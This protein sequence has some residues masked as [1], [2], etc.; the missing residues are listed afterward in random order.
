MIK[1]LK[2]TNKWYILLVS[3]ALLVGCANPSGSSDYSPELDTNIINEKTH[4]VIYNLCNEDLLVWVGDV[5]YIESW[6]KSDW[7]NAKF[8]SIC[9]PFILKSNKKFEVK[10]LP[11][12]GRIYCVSCQSMEYIKICS[13]VPVDYN[14]RF[15]FNT[16][17]TK[18]VI[19][20]T[21][22]KM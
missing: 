16:N 13:S 20:K 10:K 4:L 21:K 19:N 15:Y 2:M 8:E 1:N 3:L 12:T 17:K 5:E 7:N 18:I 22:L 6:G 11:P 14:A 9:E